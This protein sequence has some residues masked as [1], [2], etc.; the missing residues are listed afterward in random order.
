MWRRSVVRLAAVVAV[1]GALACGGGGEAVDEKG[2]ADTGALQNNPDPATGSPAGG[3]AA[4]GSTPP[5]MGPGSAVNA[6]GTADTEIFSH[7]PDSVTGSPAGGGAAPGSQ[8][9]APTPP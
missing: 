6:E 5:E 9:P 4:P 3:G 8:P 1:T 2:T 7:N